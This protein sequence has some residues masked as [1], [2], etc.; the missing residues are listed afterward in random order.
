VVEGVDC[1]TNMF[2]KLAPE[3]ADVPNTAPPTTT[4]V[5]PLNDVP[6]MVVELASEVA[7]AAFPLVFAEIVESIEICLAAEPSKVEPE[8]KTRP[9]ETVS[10]FARVELPPDTA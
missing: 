6:F 5:L 3:V 8:L 7:V 9:P 2:L 1:V 10:A 4:L